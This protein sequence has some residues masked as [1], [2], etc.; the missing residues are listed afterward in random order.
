MIRTSDLTN[1]A[2]TSWDNGVYLDGPIP[3]MQVLR[4]NDLLLSRA[5]T[6][7]RSY[8]VPD[9]GN[10]MTFAG[11]LVRFRPLPGT[12]PRF[13]SY[14]MRSSGVQQQIHSQAVTST[15]ANFNAERY[16]N[17]EF[18]DTEYEEQQK[19]AEFLDDKISR[20]DRI[21]SARREQIESLDQ[22][23]IESMRLGVAGALHQ[24]EDT[25]PSGIDWLTVVHVSGH[26][27][28]LARI[29]TL[30]RG[31]DLTDMQRRSGTVPV[32]TTAGVVGTHDKAIEDGPGVVLGRYG[33]VGN[34][35]WINEPYWPHNTTL[36]VRDP[37]G[38]DLRWLYYLLRAFPYNAMQARTAIPGVNRN[39]MATEM[40][41]WIPLALQRQAVKAIDEI[42]AQ[43]LSHKNQLTRSI[44]LL[45][46][47][48]SSLITAAVTGELDVPTAGSR[49]LE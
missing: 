40:V 36:Y 1:G 32:I 29:A 15:I 37:R 33:S 44:S 43:T 42:N 8:L 30:Q 25:R 22:L 24:G 21:I 13:L 45:T 2:L 5:G 12:D 4:A 46:E 3:G 11:F 17:L 31:V 18:P 9:T 23:F 6:I 39:D 35:H 20:I 14:A 28:K 48:K 10:G 49:N 38:N 19:I 7:G 27:L 26:E 16:A 41:P 47:Y 34:V